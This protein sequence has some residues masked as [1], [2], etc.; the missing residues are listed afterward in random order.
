ME[1]KNHFLKP[2]LANKHKSS[3]DIM[4][5]S[6]SDTILKNSLNNQSPHTRKLSSLSISP[7]NSQRIQ[8]SSPKQE[9]LFEKNPRVSLKIRLL[10]DKIQDFDCVK[11]PSKSHKSS[12]S[13][14]PQSNLSPAMIFK[15]PSPKSISHTESVY[16]DWE[17]K[18]ALEPLRTRDVKCKR[19]TLIASIKSW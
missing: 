17:I 14:I 6:P 18:Q 9:S 16:T 12:N 15:T 5:I 8:I 19:K 7:R 1:S 4:N 11:T 13:S 10:Y 3:K 2:P